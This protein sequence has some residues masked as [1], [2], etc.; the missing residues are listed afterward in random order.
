MTPADAKHGAPCARITGGF[1]KERIDT[2]IDVSIR[3]QWLA[4]ND[5]I[6]GAA[7]SHAVENFR[8]A[9]GEVSGEYS[10][11]VWQDSDV[12]KWLEAASNSLA[13]RPDPELE[14]RVDEVIRLVA[15]AQLPDGYLNTYFT[16]VAPDKRWQDLA[17][18][19]EL[20]CAGH[21]IEAAVAHNA[22]TGKTA[23]IDVAR[24][25]ADCLDRSFGPEEGKNHGCCGHPEI[26]LALFRLYG[27]TG[28]KRYR[29]LAL[30]FLDVR[31]REPALFRDKAPLGFVMP[32][33]KWFAPDYFQAHEPV[34]GQRDA[35]GHAVR[36]MYLYSA[37][38]DACLETD[39]GEELL[40]ALTGL[41]DSAV[42]RRM[43]ITGGLGSQAHGE[44]FTLDWDLP[45]DTA[46]A[47]TCASIGLV[48]WASRMSRID[49]DSRYADAAERALYNGILS[50]L[51]RD[52]SRYFYVNPLEMSPAIA[53][54]R[55]DHSHVLASR[56]AWL[57]CSCCPPNIARIVTSFGSL[58][59]GAA[60]ST[61]QVHH[62]AAS[63]AELPVA[64]KRL[65]L[66]QS[67]DYPWAGIVQ[68][69]VEPEAEL[70]FDLALRVP[71]WCESW[72]VAIN[73]EPIKLP[74]PVKGYLHL[75][76]SWRPGDLVLIDF[77]MPARL[78]RADPR[79][80]ELA[81]KL[82]VQRGP[83]VYC[84]EACDNGPDL[85]EL[86][87]DPEAA[88]EVVFDKEIL[89]GIARIYAQGVR[90][91]AEERP[92]DASGAAPRGPYYA[93]APGGPRGRP[94]RIGFVPYHA[95]GNR[96]PGNEMAVWLRE[97]S[98]R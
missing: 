72:K 62:Y 61:V 83:L 36:A 64:G 51:S 26:E 59:Y 68:L 80:R 69:R 54:A 21:L 60:W 9:A 37:M 97:G 76:R 38:A 12:A 16:I 42:S 93:Q 30:H 17:W 92:A 43:Y 41:W 39:D 56:V 95:W 4:L 78:M 63:E 94:A 91:S 58:I 2:V 77:D 22:A 48:L 44:R 49:A 71:G 10:G 86:S 18:G 65:R 75:E 66:V 32:R 96:E 88:L 46:Y 81:G 53:E 6:E 52:G 74:A 79:I 3:H 98:R 31:G 24:R 73:G 28:E 7:P 47:E 13:V 11:N 40:A 29:A 8:I 67:T 70:D 19:H 50:G 45:S 57:G 55:E 25:L 85:H 90:E 27:A 5:E 84:A 35:V 14:A 89:G 34:R 82:A 23:L 33:T 1:W 87:L 15:K 20:Y